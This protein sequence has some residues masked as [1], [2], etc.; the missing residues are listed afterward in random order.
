M[1]LVNFP[2]SWSSIYP[3]LLHAKEIGFTIADLVFPIFLWTVG[4][5]IQ[6][7]LERH[8]SET[9]SRFLVKLLIR[10]FLLFLCGI[11]LSLFPKWDFEAFRIPGVLQRIAFCYLIT[12][13]LFRFLSFSYAISISSGIALL[14]I[15]INR[16]VIIDENGFDFLC[17]YIPIEQ[18]VGANFDRFIFGNH[19]WKESKLYDPEGLVTSVCALLTVNLGL[20]ANRLQKIKLT[21]WKKMFFPIS[22]LILGLAISLIFPISK[23]NWSLSFILISAGIVEI[24]YKIFHQ[25][26]HRL[27]ESAS[28]IKF[29]L[30]LLYGEMGRYALALFFFTGV[31]ARTKIFANGRSELFNILKHFTVDA[32]LAS[33]L[34]SIFVYFILILFFQIRKKIQ[35]GILA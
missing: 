11:F 9:K 22:Y 33:L 17:E 6:L 16:F 29:I 15:C 30:Q 20:V 12:A 32:R 1:V 7:S 8:A 34:F 28:G 4:F 21:E 26:D 13:L 24:I 19:L 5:S 14:F 23:L 2:G 35:N 25:M 18:S 3:N 10:F 27:R 31:I